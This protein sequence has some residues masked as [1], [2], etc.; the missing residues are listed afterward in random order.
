MPLI[1]WRHLPTATSEYSVRHGFRSLN[2][3]ND[4]LVWSSPIQALACKKRTCAADL[5]PL[6]S[7][8]PQQGGADDVQPVQG[9]SCTGTRVLLSQRA[10]PSLA[11]Q[12]TSSLFRPRST[13]NVW[14]WRHPAGRP[15]MHARPKAFA[16]QSNDLGVEELPADYSVDDEAIQVKMQL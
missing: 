1:C 14:V 4:Y 9:Q 15:S 16:A 7:N 6:A 3:H 11:K 13:Q 2:V 10:F 12:I 5:N 8:I